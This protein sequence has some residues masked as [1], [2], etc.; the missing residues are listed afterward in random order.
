MICSIRVEGFSREVHG[1]GAFRGLGSKVSNV[2]CVGG[3][4]S[5]G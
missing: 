1:P 2:V 4:E 5:G 3:G